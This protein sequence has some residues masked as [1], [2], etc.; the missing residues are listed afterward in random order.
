MMETISEFLVTECE[1]VHLSAEQANMVLN[2]LRGRVQRLTR[3][4]TDNEGTGPEL[5]PDGWMLDRD[6]VLDL[7]NPEALL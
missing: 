1:Q 4:A 6:Q 2:A 3:L 5:A 7:L